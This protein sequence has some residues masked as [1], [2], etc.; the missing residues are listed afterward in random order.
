MGRLVCGH[1]YHVLCIKQWL[2]QK[3]T[4]PVCKT[5]A[6]K[7]WNANSRHAVCVS[8]VKLANYDVVYSPLYIILLYTHDPSV[9]SCIKKMR[10][11]W[12]CSM[13]LRILIPY[14]GWLQKVFAVSL[15][16][17]FGFCSVSTLLSVVCWSGTKIN[18]QLFPPSQNKY[19]SHLSKIEL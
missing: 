18:T 12:P 11:F 17:A 8:K 7:N 4:C 1:S 19:T 15:G 2:S 10:C 5:A 9:A 16:G 14:F 3:N 13:E 6:S